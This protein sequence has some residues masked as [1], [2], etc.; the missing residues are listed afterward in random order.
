MFERDVLLH[1]C[2]GLRCGI[3]ALHGMGV[4]RYGLGG[5]SYSPS[6]LIPLPSRRPLQNPPS[7]PRRRESI[8]KMQLERLRI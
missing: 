3:A 8:V 2:S 5:L 7:F 6:P 4:G 1:G